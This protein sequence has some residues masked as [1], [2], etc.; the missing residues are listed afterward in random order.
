M[1][2]EAA[3][4]G[5]TETHTKPP[6]IL[7]ARTRLID[8]VQFV[9]LSGSGHSFIVEGPPEQGGENAGVRPMELFLIGLGSCTSIDVIRCL[10][11]MRERISGCE[12]KITG[13]RAHASPKVF[14]RI[15]L[16]Y[17]LTGENLSRANAASAI[18]LSK[19]RFC[20]ATAMLGRTAE[21]TEDF[22]IRSA[23]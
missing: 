18:M 9:G 14:T 19:K 1:T 4:A 3:T 21:I 13:E 16:H 20:S 11:E 8:G 22:E 23:D 15:H 2:V 6:E 5:R 12:I 10:R 7:S 17:I